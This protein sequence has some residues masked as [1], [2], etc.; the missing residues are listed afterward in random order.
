MDFRLEILVKEIWMKRN[1]GFLAM[2]R[3]ESWDLLPIG[4]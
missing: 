2:V 4:F 3:Q 1:N